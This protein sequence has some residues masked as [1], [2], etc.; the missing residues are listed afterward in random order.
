MGTRLYVGNL[1]FDTT[2]ATLTEAFSDQGRRVTSVSIMTD[3]V[4]GKPRGFAFVEMG[5]AADAQSAIQALD[6]KSVD[7]R[8]L[9]VNE[10]EELKPR[11]GG[12]GGFRGD[13]GGRRERW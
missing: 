3:R 7:G 12:G 6:G 11:P 1:S 2:E 8:A 9:L 10:A 13:G 5:S 4:T